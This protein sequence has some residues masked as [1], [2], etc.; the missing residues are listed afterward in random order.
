RTALVLCSVFA[1]I[2]LIDRV[3]DP[4]RYQAPNDGVYLFV[5][6]G[7][8]IGSLLLY[9]ISFRLSRAGKNRREYLLKLVERVREREAEGTRPPKMPWQLPDSVRVN[10]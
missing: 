8:A 1:G 3:V 10:P 4:K 9:W 7:I 2:Y 5:G 6:V